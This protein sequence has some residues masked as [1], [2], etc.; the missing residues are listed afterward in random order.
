M[1][2][3]DAIL[4][5]LRDQHA[6]ISKRVEDYTTEGRGAPGFVEQ[7]QRDLRGIEQA[8]VQILSSPSG[9]PM[10]TNGDVERS[11]MNKGK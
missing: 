5:Y 3:R 7:L 1:V 8:M 6:A 2:E 4:K 11:N 10:R 9:T